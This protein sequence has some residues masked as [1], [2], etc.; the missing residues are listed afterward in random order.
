MR[1]SVKA[2]SITVT[3]NS[4]Q[5]T[6]SVIHTAK[7]ISNVEFTLIHPLKNLAL[8]GPLE[9]NVIITVIQI[10]TAQK[11]KNTKYNSTYLHGGK[12]KTPPAVSTHHIPGFIKEYLDFLM[13]LK[14]PIAH[15]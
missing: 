12:Y 14:H 15:Y 10:N 8:S 9:L 7:R 2:A 3:L 13:Q 5:R 6:A 4:K 11:K 1:S